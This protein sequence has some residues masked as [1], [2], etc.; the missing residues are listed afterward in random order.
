MAARNGLH[1]HESNVV[2]VAGVLGTGITEADEK[3]HGVNGAILEFADYA[4]ADGEA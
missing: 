2:A 4:N 3:Q 1:C